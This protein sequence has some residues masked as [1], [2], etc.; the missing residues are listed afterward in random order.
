[1]NAFQREGGEWSADGID[2]LGRIVLGMGLT[3]RQAR[4]ECQRNID[5]RE[6][7]LSR[8]PTQQLS[9]IV[10][11]DRDLLSGELSYAVKLIAQVILE[12]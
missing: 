4:E 1:M 9:E 2:S 8:T 10:N 6:E 11:T 5:K 3:E 12:R 7:F